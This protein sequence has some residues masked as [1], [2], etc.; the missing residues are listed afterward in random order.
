[1]TVMGGRRRVA[2]VKARKRNISPLKY[3]RS[4]H[5][6]LM[7]CTREI[8]EQRCIEQYY[9]RSFFLLST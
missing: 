7:Q 9:C 2:D 5:A 6:Q 1:M 3:N 8:K 4:A